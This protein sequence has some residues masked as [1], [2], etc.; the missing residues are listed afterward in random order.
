MRRLD[1]EWLVA[2]PFHVLVRRRRRHVASSPVGSASALPRKPPQGSAPTPFPSMML[3]DGAGPA[4]G[5]GTSTDG[6]RDSS[7]LIAGG[8]VPSA[9]FDAALMRH[10]AATHSARESAGRGGGHGGRGDNGNAAAEGTDATAADGAPGAVGA[11]GE[12][13]ATAGQAQ[14]CVAAYR[15][16]RSA[17]TATAPQSPSGSMRAQHGA[18]TLSSAAMPQDRSAS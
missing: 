12:D 3:A 9:G 18:G 5:D 11:G 14:L 15:L 6:S 17:E 10:L 8:S 1:P 2:A 16:R 4:L 13:D 7:P